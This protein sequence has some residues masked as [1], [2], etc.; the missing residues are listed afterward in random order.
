MD[1][2]LESLHFQAGMHDI[3]FLK[4]CITIFKNLKI[5][6]AYTIKSVWKLKK[7]YITVKTVY[8]ASL[9]PRRVSFFFVYFVDNILY[10]RPNQFAY[11]IKSTHFMQIRQI[12]K[13]RSAFSWKKDLLNFKELYP[14]KHL[15][16]STISNNQT[17]KCFW[18]VE[19]ISHSIKQ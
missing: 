10:L 18:K 16:L 15:N 3:F 12:H 8:M 5:C 1:N 4:I 2:S 11:L 7:L 17:N 6:I 13:R 19:K 14:W 9:L